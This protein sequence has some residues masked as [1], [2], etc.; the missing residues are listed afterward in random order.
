VICNAVMEF[1]ISNLHVSRTMVA[2]LAIVDARGRVNKK[3]VVCLL[4]YWTITL[5]YIFST[6]TRIINS[7]E[8]AG[9]LHFL[10][11]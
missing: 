3:C 11:S 5:A 7:P 1:I 10:V 8:N 4:T 6:E 2:V 9:I